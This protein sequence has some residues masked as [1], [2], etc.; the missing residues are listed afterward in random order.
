MIAS[1]MKSRRS[2]KVIQSLYFVT[3]ILHNLVF[4]GIL[5][6]DKG[7]VW[8]ACE[9]CAIMMNIFIFGICYCDSSLAAAVYGI[10]L[11]ITV[12]EYVLVND[13]RIAD[14]NRMYW[15]RMWYAIFATW[16]MAWMVYSERV[17]KP[18]QRRIR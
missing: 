18:T 1:W 7:G 11:S 2:L 17:G 13:F 12:Y 15:I 14:A 5:H 3:V 6:Q 9:V 4:Y 10:L 8:E 16:M